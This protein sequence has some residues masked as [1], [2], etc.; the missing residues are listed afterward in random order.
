MYGETYIRNANL[1]GTR[2][3]QM[4]LSSWP[5]ERGYIGV[6]PD[7]KKWVDCD[8]PPRKFRLVDFAGTCYAYCV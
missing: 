3:L 8:A 1:A 5:V 7:A 6:K 2:D 4:F